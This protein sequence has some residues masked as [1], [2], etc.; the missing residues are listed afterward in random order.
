MRHSL[1]SYV[2]AGVFFTLYGSVKYLPTPVGDLCRFLCLWPFVKAIKSI[3][4]KD[5][6]TFWFPHNI[7]IGRNV[8]I[9]EW[10]FIDGYGGVE[11]G[12]CCRIA[13]NCSLV[14]EDHGFA[15]PDTPIYRQKK[16]GARIR[17]ERDVW[18]GCGVRVLKG[19]TIG[20]GSIIGANSLVTKNIPPYSIAVGSPA[21]VIRK[22][23]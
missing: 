16:V 15:D 23:K 12:D 22:R 21:R 14:S 5:G 7:V 4:I 6:A 11:I 19:V 18:L 13:H 8:T 3:A 1:F 20:E 17:L 10:C 9:N 2:R